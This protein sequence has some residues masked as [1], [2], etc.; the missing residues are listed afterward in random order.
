MKRWLVGAVVAVCVVIIAAITVYV[1]PVFTVSRVNVEGATHANVDDIT[2]ATG[3]SMGSNLMRVDTARAADSV[4]SVAWVKKATVSRVLP[5]TVRVV[6]EEQTAV[7]YVTRSDGTHLIND[8]GQEFVVAPAEIGML[9]IVGTPEGVD[10]SAVYADVLTVVGVLEP[11]VRAELARV[12][13]PTRYQISLEL[14]DGRT[15]YWGSAEQAS[16]KSA[17]TTIV[18]T[19]P[20]T[21]YNVSAPDLVTVS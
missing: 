10:N 17:A 15:V 9:E 13:A 3:I 1:A 7:A 16:A 21:N 12:S 20:G 6:V 14:L 19:R 5:S 4:I 2:A 18:L 8:R 11:S